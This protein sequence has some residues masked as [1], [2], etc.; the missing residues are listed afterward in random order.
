MSRFQL[1]ASIGFTFDT[2]LAVARMIY[3]GFF[4]R[5]PQA[6]DHRRARR[7]RAAVP[8][9]R[10]WTSAS[11]T[12]RRA[13]RRSRRGPSEYLPQIYA[14]AVVFAPDVLELCVKIF[15]ADNVLYGSDYPHTIGD[16]PG[17]LTRVN[18]L[19]DAARD[20]VRGRNAAHF[21]LLVDRAVTQIPTG[22]WELRCDGPSALLLPVLVPKFI[23]CTHNALFAAAGRLDTFS[24]S[25]SVATGLV[26]HFDARLVA[27]VELSLR[28]SLTATVA[29]GVPRPAAR[30]RARARPLSGTAR[31]HGPVNALHGPA[32]G[33]RRPRRLPA[34]V[35]R[36]PARRARPPLHADGDGDRADD[37]GRCRSSPRCRARSSPTRGREYREQLRSLGAT[38]VARRAHAAV[39]RALLAR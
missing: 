6:Q 21:R 31:A 9:S 17:C 20:K 12:F 27:I 37:P 8:R 26:T 33:R 36:R 34:S 3:D 28:V 38:H 29:R 11:T 15:G 16:M 13:A 19:P 14:D 22:L 25:L 24:D 30:R 23:N 18:G 4:D 7:R 1:T 39:G 10:A 35:A 2:S 32:A 5:Y